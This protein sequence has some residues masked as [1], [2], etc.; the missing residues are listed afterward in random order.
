MDLLN[1]IDK[2]VL[3][4]R[5][6]VAAGSNNGKYAHMVSNSIVTL[7][8]KSD[9]YIRGLALGV[10]FKAEVSELPDIFKSL[11]LE[12]VKIHV[13][14][15]IEVTIYFK[16]EVLYFEYT[17]LIDRLKYVAEECKRQDLII[18]RLCHRKWLMGSNCQI[19]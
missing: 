19:V 4:F 7:I 15:D 5:N 8:L 6:V 13:N 17:E 3:S 14:R 12:R 2:G 18:N 10:E 16:P 11:L 1:E 9:C